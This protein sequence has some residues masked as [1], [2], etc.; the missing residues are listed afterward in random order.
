[1]SPTPIEAMR[2]ALRRAGREQYLADLRG[3][4][5]QRA[6]TI[7]SGKQYKRRDKHAHNTQGEQ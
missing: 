2:K 1:M 5:R 6:V 7:P 3:G 4:R